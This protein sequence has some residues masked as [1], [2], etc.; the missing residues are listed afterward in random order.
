VLEL[1]IDDLRF[2]SEEVVQYFQQAIGQELPSETIQALEERTDGRC[3]C[4]YA[5]RGDTAILPVAG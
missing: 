2:A 5:R 1:G 3:Q 4:R